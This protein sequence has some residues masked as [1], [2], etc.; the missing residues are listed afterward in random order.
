MTTIPQTNPHSEYLALQD[1]IDHALLTVA[2]KGHY[3]LGPQVENFEKEFASYTGAKHCVGVASGTDAIEL[4]L[5]TLDIGRGD[6]VIT[7]SMTAVATVAAIVRTGATPLFVDIGADS[8]N[9]DTELLENTIKAVHSGKYGSL[10]KKVSAIVAVH[11]YGHPADIN[12]ISQIA[13]ANGCYLIEDCAQAHGATYGETSVGSWGDLAAFSFY[14]TKNLAA[15]GDAGAI[16]TSKT[17]YFQR[18]ITLRQYGW[19]QRHISSEPGINSRLDEIQAAVLRVKLGKLD[20]FVGKRRNIAKL[21]S[22]LIDNPDIQKPAEGNGYRHAYHQ[23]VV[24]SNNRDGLANYLSNR[25][26][27]TAIHYPLPVHRQP[28]YQDCPVGAGGLA[29]T[30][31]LSKEILS[32]PMWAYLQSKQVE[33]VASVINQWSENPA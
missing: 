25:D 14:P 5:R 3:V 8:F 18:A 19:Q 15:M 17:E 6:I 7:A 30:E 24:R 28:A 12:N 4:A 29:K 32:L 16:T 23:Y 9:M 20:E 27:Q 2:H 22:Q 31:Q 10:G 26:I 33:Q 1:D 13:K 21:Y 11:L